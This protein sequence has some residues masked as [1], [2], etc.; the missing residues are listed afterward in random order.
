MVVLLATSVLEISYFHCVLVLVEESTFDD[1]L[2]R[3][4]AMYMYNYT[5]LFNVK[6]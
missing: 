4:L 6:R 3:D 1:C 2:K 5:Y